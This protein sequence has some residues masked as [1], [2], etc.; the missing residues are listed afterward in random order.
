MAT[1]DEWTHCGDWKMIAPDGR[2][3]LKV[4][5]ADA[6]GNISESLWIQRIA[7]DDMNGT[8]LLANAPLSFNAAP[9]VAVTFFGGD[10]KTK[11]RFNTAEAELA[12][13]EAFGGEE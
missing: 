13:A 2:V 4:A 8:G 1:I 11:P 7:G 12:F 3:F 5:A 9:G 6:D 10:E